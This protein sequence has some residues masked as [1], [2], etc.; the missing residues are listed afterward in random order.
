MGV[1]IM[2]DKYKVTLFAS[3]GDNVTYHCD[4][5]ELPTLKQRIIRYSHDDEPE[6]S[7]REVWS[8]S[9]RSLSILRV[10]DYL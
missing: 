6:G 8:S 5:S 10:K 2:T 3:N 1:K 9:L 7:M 4:E